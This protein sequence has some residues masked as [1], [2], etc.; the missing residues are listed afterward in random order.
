MIYSSLAFV[1]GKLQI[2]GSF[3]SRTEKSAPMNITLIGMAGAGKSTIGRVLAKRLDYTFIDVDHL[4]TENTGMPLQTLIDNEGD[5]A[6]IRFEEE[7]ILKLGQ[8]FIICG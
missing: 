2:A 3:I 5:S 1:S 4:I 6:L 8:A 7:A